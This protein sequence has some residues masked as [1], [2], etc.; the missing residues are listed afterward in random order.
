MMPT[1][2]MKRKAGNNGQNYRKDVSFQTIKPELFTNED[3]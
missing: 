3:I 2:T 1:L